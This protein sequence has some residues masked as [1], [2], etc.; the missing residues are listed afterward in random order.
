MR[1]GLTAHLLL[2]WP[3]DRINVS[4]H[5]RTRQG[6][7][8]EGGGLTS[9]WAVANT[10]CAPLPGHWFLQPW[11]VAC[12]SHRADVTP[13]LRCYNWCRAE[14]TFPLS[15]LSL[16]FSTFSLS[17]HLSDYLYRNLSLNHYHP[18][19]SVSLSVS[20]LLCHPLRWVPGV[21]ALVVSH[22]CS[23]PPDR[24]TLHW[25]RATNTYK[26]MTDCV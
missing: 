11:A 26:H 12:H 25:Q 19:L 13:P 1:E 23:T 9:P 16:S 6:R 22:D 7:G 8:G 10:A 5:D 4:L 15:L 24:K 2:A 17:Q 21:S 20:L 14:S 18:T 3:S